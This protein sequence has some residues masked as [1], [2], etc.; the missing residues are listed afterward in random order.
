[1]WR[2]ALS[3]SFFAL[4]AC[5]NRPR[6]PPTAESP[7]TAEVFVA[8]NSS[9]IAYEPGRNG[10]VAPDAVIGLVLTASDIAIDA[11]GKTYVANDSIN[12][13]SIFAPTAAGEEPPIATIRGGNTGLDSPEGIALDASGNIY[14]ANFGSYDRYVGKVTVYPTG[15]EGNAVPIATISGMKTGLH[16]SSDIAVDSVGRIYVTNGGVLGDVASVTVY[17]PGSDGDV[18]PIATISGS[19]TGLHWPQGIAVDAMGRIYVANAGGHPGLTASVTVYRRGSHGDVAPIATIRGEASGIGSAQGV[20]VDSGGKIYV[21]NNLWMGEIPRRALAKPHSVSVYRGGSSGDVAPIATI[22]GPGTGLDGPRAIALDPEGRIHVANVGSGSNGYSAKITVYP[23]GAD[24]DVKPIT[25]I[26]GTVDTGINLPMGVALDSMGR[27]YVTNSESVTAYPPGTDRN[28]RPT[29]TIRGGRTRLVRPEAIT[30]DSADNIYVAN[31]KGTYPTGSVTV[32]RPGDDGD[33]EPS[34]VIAGDAIGP[35]PRGIAVDS[36]GN[37]YVAGAGGADGI[38]IYAAGSSRDAAPIATVAGEHTAIAG[39]TGIALDSI[40][41]IYCAN[42]GRTA[43]DEGSVTVYP[44][45]GSLS[46]KP[47]D[48]DV[49][50][51]ATLAGPRSG[52]LHPQGIALDSIDRIYVLNLAYE[53]SNAPRFYTVLGSIAVYSP[54]RGRTGILDEAPVARIFGPNTNLDISPTG[55]AVFGPLGH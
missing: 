43:S 52:L 33:V 55:I 40:G 51:I 1:M 36:N 30:V 3:L 17:A 37:L 38:A 34:R 13:I 42:F 49:K 20:A 10:D 50:P 48:P 28:V 18:A 4:S 22:S 5:L 14:V 46:G 32:Y 16:A 15:S 23:A 21:T 26:T 19:K 8:T 9:V 35:Y 47:G 2:A 29:A 6:T 12:T 53:S 31:Q 27:I 54:L 44:P 11:I 41:R 24:G 7:P 39:P 25:T 45:L